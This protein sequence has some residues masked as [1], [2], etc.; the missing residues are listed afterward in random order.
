MSSSR[1][2]RGAGWPARYSPPIS[3]TEIVASLAARLLVARASGACVDMAV[4]VRIDD[5]AFSDARI[6][7]LAS[8]L[9][10]NRYDALGRLACLWRQATQEGAYWLPE[11]FVKVIVDPELLI[12]S[13]LARREK[14]G[15]YVCGSRGRIE[16]LN[17]LRENARK[18]GEARRLPKRVPRTKPAASPP[19]PAP[20]PVTAT[21]TATT[22]KDLS[23]E[24]NLDLAEQRA[25]SQSAEPEKPL[26]P[27]PPMSPVKITIPT[28]GKNSEDYPITEADVNEWHE[29][30]P[31]VPIM[32]ELRE[33]RQW[34]ISN[35]TKRKTARG[36]RRFITSWLER[37]QNRG[38]ARASPVHGLQHQVDYKPPYHLPFPAK[39]A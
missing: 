8:L 29:A 26:A 23:S 32:Q 36:M 15:I 30:Y 34:A 37:E 6:D 13:R 27:A 11:G 12:E 1:S 24:G 31:A 7:H 17:K 22:K 28:A 14:N 21:I 5:E 4:S 20:A 35:P 10:S 2:A 39:E 18:G 38:G 16:W 3:G 19:A 33:M 25:Q 9:N